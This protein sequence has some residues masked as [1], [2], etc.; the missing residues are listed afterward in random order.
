MNLALVLCDDAPTALA[1]S[2]YPKRR[3]A[4]CDTGARELFVGLPLEIILTV[5]QLLVL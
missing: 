5:V 3:Y 1:L 4:R 2:A